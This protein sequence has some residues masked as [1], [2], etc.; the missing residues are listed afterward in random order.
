MEDFSFFIGIDISKA[1]LYFAVV[2]S[3]KLLF[4]SQSTNG[5]AG[6]GMFIKQ[7]KTRCPDAD[8]N[9]SLHCMEHTGIC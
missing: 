3:N 9:N 7:L 5:K 1:T 6:I 2:A 4:Y 8:L